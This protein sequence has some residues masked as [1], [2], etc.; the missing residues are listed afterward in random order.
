VAVAT[1]AGLSPAD[2]TSSFSAAPFASAAPP[3]EFD[4]SGVSTRLGQSS[5]SSTEDLLAL[6]DDFAATS[7]RTRDA[8]GTSMLSLAA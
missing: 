8:T 6:R 4:C 1:F 5:R 7:S 3:G 2:A